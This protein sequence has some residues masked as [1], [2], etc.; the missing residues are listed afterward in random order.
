LSDPSCG[1]IWIKGVCWWNLKGPLA[2]LY[3]ERNDPGNAGNEI[4]PANDQEYFVRVKMPAMVRHEIG[5]DTI[6]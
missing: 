3:R 6:K 1:N 2:F 4:N 5:R